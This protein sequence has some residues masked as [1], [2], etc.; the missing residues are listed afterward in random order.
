MVVEQPAIEKFLK[1]K[2]AA[3]LSDKTTIDIQNT[4]RSISTYLIRVTIHDTAGTR[5]LHD[6]RE[7]AAKAPPIIVTYFDG[8]SA[9]N[10]FNC[11]QTHIKDL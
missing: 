8:D 2:V 9:V 3:K 1:G 10:T 5:Q 7:K 4:R 11:L 6:L